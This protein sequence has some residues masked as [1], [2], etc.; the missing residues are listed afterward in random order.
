MSIYPE[1]ADN[2][3]R[4]AAIL[5]LVSDEQI[6]GIL[7]QLSASASRP[8]DLVSKASG[9]ERSVYRKLHELSDLGLVKKSSSS[10]RTTYGLTIFGEEVEKFMEHFGEMTHCNKVYQSLEAIR[11][12]GYNIDFSPL[13]LKSLQ[14]VYISQHKLGRILVLT[15]KEKIARALSNAVHLTSSSLLLSTRYFGSSMFSDILA[16]MNRG[17]SC[18]ILLSSSYDITDFICTMFSRGPSVFSEIVESDL[19]SIR[20]GNLCTSYFVGDEKYLMLELPKGEGVGYYC[21]I[22]INCPELAHEMGTMFSHA[23][24]RSIDIRLE[25]LKDSL[26]SFT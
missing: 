18:K 7:A 21:F 12:N 23:W 1:D 6:M 20:L 14:A 2:R 15:K 13:D 19:I 22:S 4:M 26:P 24:G 9:S 3:R 5:R 11:N 10:D 16:A 17:V 25:K 8:S